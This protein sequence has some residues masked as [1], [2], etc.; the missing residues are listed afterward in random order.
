MRPAPERP[1]TVT[2]VKPARERWTDLRAMVASTLGR[3]PNCRTGSAFRGL[4]AHRERCPVC[5]VRFERDPGSWLGAAVLAYG[6]TIVVV[7]AVAWFLIG[8]GVRGGLEWWLVG[9][10]LVSVLIVYR[11]A[12]GWWLWWMWAAGW[13]HRD[14]EDPDAS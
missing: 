12:K 9:S 2:A 10:A 4:Y 7:G 14:R 6:V 5:G 13:V 1:T 3:C 8:R 11:P